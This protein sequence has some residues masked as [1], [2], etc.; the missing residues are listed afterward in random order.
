MA[1]RRPSVV[2]GGGDQ[3]RSP[4]RGV[5]GARDNAFSPGGYFGERGGWN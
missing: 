3:R 5:P 4:V 2:R 1:E